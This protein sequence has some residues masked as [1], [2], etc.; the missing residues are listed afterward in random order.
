MSGTSRRE[1]A[2]SG[3][4]LGLAGTPPA[5]DGLG[6]GLGAGV[7]GMA[8]PV[9]RKLV[10]Y[11]ALAALVCGVVSGSLIAAPGPPGFF[12][13]G[14]GL[15]MI[16]IAV[17][18]ARAYL[19]PDRLTLAAF[20]LGLANAA[21]IDLANMPENSA[22]ALLRGIVLAFAFF[23]LRDV[24]RRLRHRHGLGLGDVKLAAVAGAWLDWALIPAAIEIAALTALFAYIA[25]QLVLQQPLRAAA[26]LPFGLFF[27]PAIWIGWLLGARFLQS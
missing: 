15:L 12:G 23:A 9:P 10:I 22:M 7:R 16:A 2:Q 8:K 20:L 19:I 11:T 17:D 3:F 1:S 18:D 27:A 25:S 21:A 4:A 6:K 13:A 24:Y 5:S 26:K 14:L